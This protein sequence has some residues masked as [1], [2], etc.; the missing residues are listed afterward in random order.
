MQA[1]KNLGMEGITAD[2]YHVG[3]IMY[4]ATILAK[5]YIKKS[6]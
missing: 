6:R 4:D 5:D 3:D 1:V 2:V